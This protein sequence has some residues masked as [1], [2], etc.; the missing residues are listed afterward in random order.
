MFISAKLFR[1]NFTLIGS[2]VIFV[3]II[4]IDAVCLRS[5]LSGLVEGGLW[6][7]GSDHSFDPPAE[8]SSR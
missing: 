7:S 8:L 6:L 3:F 1:N 5:V 2:I 4:L